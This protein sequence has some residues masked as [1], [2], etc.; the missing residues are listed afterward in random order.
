MSQKVKVRCAKCGRIAE[1]SR[2]GDFTVPYLGLCDSCLD[3]M[4]STLRELDHCLPSEEKRKEWKA[5]FGTDDAR[6]VYVVAHCGKPKIEREVRCNRCHNIINDDITDFGHNAHWCSDCVKKDREES[7]R[8]EKSR[9]G[10][11]GI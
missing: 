6:E 2:D 10:K 5:R 8:D 3:N 1:E 9:L 7:E 11:F 4:N